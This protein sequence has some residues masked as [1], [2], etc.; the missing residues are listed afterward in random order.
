MEDIGRMAGLGNRFQNRFGRG[1]PADAFPPTP[2]V[3]MVETGVK[4]VFSVIDDTLTDAWNNVYFLL[5]GFWVLRG[6]ALRYIKTDALL[7]FWSN[8]DMAY[9]SLSIGD[10]QQAV[11]GAIPEQILVDGEI[12]AWQALNWSGARYLEGVTIIEGW[13]YPGPDT[14]G[15]TY[16]LRM[17]IMAEK[18]HPGRGI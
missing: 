6:V 7:N 1:S 12:G 4:R 11:Q 9:I 16:T 10:P 5:E 8:L 14:V 3:P 17:T 15:G 18:L 13:C 2:A